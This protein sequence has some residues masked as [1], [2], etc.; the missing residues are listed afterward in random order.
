MLTCLDVT[1]A[2]DI[3][4][5]LIA[6]KWEELSSGIFDVMCSRCTRGLNTLACRAHVTLESLQVMHH[7]AW[8]MR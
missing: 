8:A 7:C 3:H 2:V 5:H 6:R 4:E 1:V